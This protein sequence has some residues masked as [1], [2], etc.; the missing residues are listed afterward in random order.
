MNGVT[1]KDHVVVY[2]SGGNF[3]CS[4]HPIHEKTAL[5][6]TQ[7]EHQSSLNLPHIHYLEDA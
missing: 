2:P 5:N 4:G 3:S 1:R 7:F 6:E